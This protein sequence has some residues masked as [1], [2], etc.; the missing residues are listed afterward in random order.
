MVSNI[1]PEQQLASSEVHV[2]HGS[3]MTIAVNG[4]IPYGGEILTYHPHYGSIKGPN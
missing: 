2:L 3:H 4:E 1:S